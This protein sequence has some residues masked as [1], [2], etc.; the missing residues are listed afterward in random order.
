MKMISFK[1]QVDTDD[2]GHAGRVQPVLAA[3]TVFAV[4]VV[5][6]VLHEQA[7]HLPAG[8]LQELGTDGGV[9]PPGE[10][11]DNLTAFAVRYRW[12]H[13]IITL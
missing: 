3:G 13:A 5:L 6:P 1:K 4:I 12:F 9:N 8:L 7:G 10:A 11:N 2:I